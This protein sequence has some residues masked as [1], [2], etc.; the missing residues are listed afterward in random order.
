MA[1]CDRCY[2]FVFKDNNVH[3]EKLHAQEEDKHVH[4]EEVEL[5][6]YQVH[7]SLHKLMSVHR[8]VNCCTT[9]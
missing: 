9:E 6:F 2:F 5:C 7:T 8:A 1:E 4:H 3:H